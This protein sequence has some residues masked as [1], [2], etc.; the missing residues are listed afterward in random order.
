MSLPDIF[1]GREAPAVSS[2]WIDMHLHRDFAGKQRAVEPYAVFRRHC[3]VIAA[4]G[5]EYRG[6][7]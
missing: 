5:D 4:Q 1:F 2:G 6:I 3:R 7:V